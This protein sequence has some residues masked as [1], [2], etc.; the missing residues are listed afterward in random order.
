MAAVETVTAGS[1]MLTLV[2]FRTDAKVTKGKVAGE[3]PLL[4]GDWEA[5]W[6]GAARGKRL[7]GGEHLEDCE[8]DEVDCEKEGELCV[9]DEAGCEVDGCIINEG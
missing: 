1:V 4:G 2:D 5:G 3:R 8:R 9:V 7:D 6:K